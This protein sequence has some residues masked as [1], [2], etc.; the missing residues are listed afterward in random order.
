[1]TFINV[2][3]S[4]NVDKNAD[5][6]PELV[7]DIL[8]CLCSFSRFFF[9]MSRNVDFLLLSLVLNGL[10]GLVML[11]AELEAMDA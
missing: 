7:L 6:P 2:S 4:Y 8:E 9:S 5:N 1:M 10:L 3:D 11:T